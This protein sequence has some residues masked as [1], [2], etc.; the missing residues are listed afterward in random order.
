MVPCPFGDCEK[1]PGHARPAAVDDAIVAIDGVAVDDVDASHR[2]VDIKVK[3]LTQKP[4][5]HVT[6]V[7]PAF[8]R[9]R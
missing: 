9:P 3:R 2:T 6:R 7:G 5:L 1:Q 4:T 8:V